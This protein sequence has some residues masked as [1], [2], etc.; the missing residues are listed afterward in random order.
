MNHRGKQR[1]A[2][3]VVAAL[4]AAMLPPAVPAAAAV[5]VSVATP[6]VTLRSVEMLSASTAVAVATNGSIWRTTD[7]GGDW[8]QVRTA[9]T[10][11]F[12]AVDFWDTSK[13][14]AVDLAGKVAHTADGGTT[15][16]VVDDN[17][18][19]QPGTRLVDVH[20]LG[21]AELVGEAKQVFHGRSPFQSAFS[22]SAI[23]AARNRAASPPV[24]A[25]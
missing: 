12:R 5:S 19:A 7:G 4:L 6:S 10:Y 11:D 14:V 3:F 21:G 23:A 17:D 18:R 22:K 1:I 25:R 13:G 8:T 24:T 2:A 20:D 9:D 16:H 15:P